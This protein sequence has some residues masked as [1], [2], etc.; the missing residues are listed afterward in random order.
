MV[1]EVATLFEVTVIIVTPVVISLVDDPEVQPLLSLLVLSQ[2]TMVLM[3]VLGAV[4][5]KVEVIT[6]E[7][8]TEVVY[9]TPSEEEE[10]AEV[11]DGCKTEEPEVAVV[12]PGRENAEEGLG[13]G[14]LE[15]EPLSVS[16]VP[17]TSVE[18]VVLGEVVEVEGTSIDDVSLEDE[19]KDE[20]K[21]E[22][23]KVVPRVCDS[24]EIV[25]F[26]ELS[27]E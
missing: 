14:L 11:D 15:E 22:E 24:V 26:I 5:R 25:D 4:L 9:S 1:Y 23:S 13:V 16:L 7:E 20:E 3:M 19:E 6:K 27:V 17:N 12:V 10:G 8:E 2:L 21:D 18:G